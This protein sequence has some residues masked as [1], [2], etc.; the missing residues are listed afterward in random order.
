MV[1]G[2]RTVRRRLDEAGLSG[3]VARKK[4][5]LTKR[6]KQ[7]RLAWAKERNNWTLHEWQSIIWSD[8]SKFYLFGNDGKVFVRR[9]I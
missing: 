6:H 2:A 7:V 4:P 3:R 1:I 9:R 5:L 8:E